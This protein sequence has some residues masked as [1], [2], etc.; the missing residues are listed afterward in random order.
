MTAIPIWEAGAD[1][2]LRDHG[3]FDLN[4]KVQ[5][6]DTYTVRQEERTRIREQRLWLT[7]TVHVTQK[8]GSK[9][10]PASMWKSQASTTPETI[11]H[12]WRDWVPRAQWPARGV[13]QIAL[14]SVRNC[15]R[16]EGVLQSKTKSSMYLSP[17]HNAHV[18]T[19]TYLHTHMHGYSD[20]RRNINNNLIKHE[21]FKYLWLNIWLPRQCNYFM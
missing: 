12:S 15:L 5:S 21:W 16:K 13:D 18:S 2:Y 17:P 11:V 7:Y 8:C 10:S 14:G 20:P 9:L 6:S 1:E 4:S 19:C 3:L